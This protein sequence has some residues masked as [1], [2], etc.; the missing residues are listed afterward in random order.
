VTADVP[1]QPSRQDKDIETV[2][3]LI[4]AGVLGPCHHRWPEMKK[5]A[6][7]LGCRPEDAIWR[8]RH[9]R[10]SGNTTTPHTP[11]DLI[12]EAATR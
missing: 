1:T 3:T 9:G 4:R 2:R 12:R 8:V 10:W 11:A 7:R 5:T 6:R